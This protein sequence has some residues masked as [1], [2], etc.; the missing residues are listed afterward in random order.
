MYI[1]LIREGF[2][3]VSSEVSFAG[4]HRSATFVVVQ[5]NSCSMRLG[6]GGLSREVDY[7]RLAK[8]SDH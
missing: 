2:R 8:D 5:E 3:I 4:W 7:E 6:T 1:L